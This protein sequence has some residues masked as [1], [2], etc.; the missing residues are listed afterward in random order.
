MFPSSLYYRVAN[1]CNV[2]CQKVTNFQEPKKYYLITVTCPLQTIIGATVQP[3]L[4]I[5]ST[6]DNV[7]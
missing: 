5:T 4:S 3:A 2:L 7:S 6:I 1:D